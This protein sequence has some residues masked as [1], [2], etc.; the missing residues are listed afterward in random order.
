LLP[1]AR[2]RAA[3]AKDLAMGILLSHQHR[4]LQRAARLV[5]KE[6]SSSYTRALALAKRLLGV[7]KKASGR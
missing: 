4:K 5:L 3:S 1:N 2:T 7:P 6:G